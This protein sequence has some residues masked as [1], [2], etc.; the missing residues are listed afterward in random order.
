MVTKESSLKNVD[1]DILGKITGKIVDFYAKIEKENIGNPKI[2]DLFKSVNGIKD[3]YGKLENE[4]V[5]K[6]A[7]E[8]KHM[9]QQNKIVDWMEKNK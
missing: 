5:Q 3:F 7:P 6:Y 1:G 9:N 8:L 4:K 2:N